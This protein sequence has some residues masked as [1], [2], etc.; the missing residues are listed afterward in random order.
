MPV[1]SPPRSPE[2]C[3]AC[4]HAEITM[5]A[6]F[7]AEEAVLGVPELLIECQRCRT[8]W[9]RA[10]D[11]SQ[12]Q[13]LRVTCWYCCRRIEESGTGWRHAESHARYCNPAV[14]GTVAAPW[15]KR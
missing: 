10:R 8:D 14:P 7:G 5:V 4:G 11:W 9:V 2:K 6:M 1:T 3:P 15:A 12:W 13:F